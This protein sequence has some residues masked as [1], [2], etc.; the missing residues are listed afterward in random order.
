MSGFPGFD[1]RNPGVAYSQL[2]KTYYANG[3][4]SISF[5]N[6][7]TAYSKYVITLEQITPNT[8]GVTFKVDYKIKGTLGGNNQGRYI[9]ATGSGS[10]TFNGNAVGTTPRL[11]NTTSFSTGSSNKSFGTIE[12]MGFGGRTDGSQ[13]F[14]KSEFYYRTTDAANYIYLLT[15]NTMTDTTTP[16]ELVFSMS[17]GTI[18]TGIFR[19]YG[20]T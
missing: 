20:I 3:D 17:S 8:N 4:T 5:P 1:I 10:M 16:D 11:T 7:T 14:L 12:V 2:L 6:L 9:T 19:L 15:Y 18:A 13:G